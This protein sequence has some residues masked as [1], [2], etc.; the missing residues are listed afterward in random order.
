MINIVDDGTLPAR[1]QSKISI[2]STCN[3]GYLL[4]ERLTGSCPLSGS[5]KN[6][7]HTAV[8]G[9]ICETKN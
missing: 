4:R 8:V 9:V 2:T 1:G 5:Q 3:N 6:S 7:R